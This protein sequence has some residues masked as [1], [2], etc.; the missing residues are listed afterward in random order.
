MLSEQATSYTH[1][2]RQQPVLIYIVGVKR[3][4]IKEEE[5]R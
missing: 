5:D 1:P 3:I 2:P 4:I